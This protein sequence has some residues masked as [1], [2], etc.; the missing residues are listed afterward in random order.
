MTEGVVRRRT[1]PSVR[2]KQAEKDVKKIKKVWRFEN[3]SYLC[4]VIMN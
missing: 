4:S 3:C 2:V 1:T